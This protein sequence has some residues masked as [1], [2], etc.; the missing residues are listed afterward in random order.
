MQKC[1]L[2]N[3]L[4]LREHMHNDGKVHAHLTFLKQYR[5]NALALRYQ[6]VR[7]K[8]SLIDHHHRKREVERRERVR[9]G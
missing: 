2:Y 3:H 5:P 6:P 8:A 1:V 7:N 4:F 9:E